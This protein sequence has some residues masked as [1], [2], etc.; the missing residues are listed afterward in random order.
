MSRSEREAAPAGTAA[1]AF[2]FGEFTLD[3]DNGRFRRGE[4]AVELPSRAFDALV[5]LVT[6]RHRLVGKNEIIASIWQDVAVTDD[7]LVNVISVLRRELGDDRSDPKYIKTVPRRGYR[8]VGPVTQLDKPPAPASPGA[9]AAGVR[10]HASA[11]AEPPGIRPDVPAGAARAGMRQRV[12]ERIERRPAAAAIWL[13]GGISLAA[14]ALVFTIAG[15]HEPEPTARE[16]RPATIRFSHAPPAGTSIVSGGVLSPDGRYL[17]FV[18]RDENTGTPELW[19]R[20]LASGALRKLGGTAGASKPFW[21]PDAGRIGFFANNALL[22]TTLSAERPRTITHVDL[23]SAG[24]SWGP[25]DTILFAEWAGGIYSVQA[26]GDGPIRAVVPL[27]HGAND[28]AVTWPQILPDGRHFLYHV[29][30]LDPAHTGT[31]VGDLVTGDSYRLVDTQSPAVY[32]QGR[33]LHVRDDML[34][35]DELSPDRLE[36]TGRAHIVARNVA[37]PSLDADGMVS[38]AGDVLAFEEGPRHQVLSWF[39]RSGKRMNGLPMPTVVYNPRLSPDQSQL[40]ATGSITT[41]PGLWLASASREEYARLEPD[42]IAPLWAPDGRSIA[43]TS[44]GGFDLIVRTMDGDGAKRRLLSDAAVKILNDWSPDGAEIIYTTGHRDPEH[45]TDGV[46]GHG[47]GLDLWATRVETGDA[48]PLLATP[49]N[50]MQARISPDGNWIA[51]ASDESG[52]LEVYV[53]RYPDLGA[54]RGISTNGGG[55]P[56]WRA[57]QRELFYLSAD[58]MI[59]SVEIESTPAAGVRFATPRTLFAAPLSGDAEDARDH[60]LASTDGNQFL[61]DGTGRPAQERLI[62]V[63]VNWADEPGSHHD[64]STP[65]A[66]P[67]SQLLQ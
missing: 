54:K 44:R 46:N 36:L 26:S 50:E 4:T 40:L 32:W 11:G 6:H 49:S 22:S 39:D 13:S 63:L 2:A 28:I 14:A 16:A 29:V 30:N 56:Q 9:Q 25:D 62:T 41:N 5:L 10:S 38:A 48:Q 3:V 33:L 15:T 8:F 67:I 31:Y 19:V 66:E 43:Y 12:L 27:D 57:D 34:I 23:A 18:A 51:Y 35:A 60:Y 53:Q 55:Q 52:T 59:M 7:S 24:G 45:R 58:R 37:A 21:A 64:V 17:A 1:G 20:I 47:T 65:L 61:I 42:A